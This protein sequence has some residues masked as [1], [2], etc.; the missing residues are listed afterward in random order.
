MQIGYDFIE[1]LIQE[2]N[3]LRKQ[4]LPY[5]NKGFVNSLRIKDVQAYEKEIRNLWEFYYQ[6]SITRKVLKEHK[7]KKELTSSSKFEQLAQGE[8]K[9]YMDFKE[10]VEENLKQFFEEQQKGKA[11]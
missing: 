3:S 8:Q 1:R 7:I 9:E 10:E 6:E 4:L 5:Q 2:I 11:K